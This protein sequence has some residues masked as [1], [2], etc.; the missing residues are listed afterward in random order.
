VSSDHA[1]DTHSGRLQHP[2]VLFSV[3]TVVL[4]SNLSYCL[5]LMCF[6]GPGNGPQWPQTLLLLFLYLVLLLV[7]PT[8]A[9]SFHGPDAYKLGLEMDQHVEIIAIHGRHRFYRAFPGPTATR[10]CSCYFNNFAVHASR[11][12]Q[13]PQY[14][15]DQVSSRIMMSY[16]I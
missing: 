13:I 14:R 12:P 15:V 3:A 9:F 2:C 10:C 7:G 6:F 11:P 16:N 5:R 1:C 8:K 4:V